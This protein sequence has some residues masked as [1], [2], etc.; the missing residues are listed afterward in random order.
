M[1]IEPTKKVEAMENNKFYDI[2]VQIRN[3]MLMNKRTMNIDDVALYTGY[4]KSYLY[5]LTSESKI[6]HFKPGGKSI[7]FKRIEIDEWLTRNPIKTRYQIEE[8]SNQII[9]NHKLR[10]NGKSN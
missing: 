3:L 2:L 7:F 9:N 10:K 1:S 5:K 8:E 6:P 4:E